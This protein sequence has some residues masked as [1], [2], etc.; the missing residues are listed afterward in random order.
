M[1][2]PGLRRIVCPESQSI[3]SNESDGDYQSAASSL[4]SS[5]LYTSVLDDNDD[6]DDN[7]IFNAITEETWLTP[8]EEIAT[9]ASNQSRRV[10]YGPV[11]I[12]PSPNLDE[13]ADQISD[14]SPI[15]AASTSSRPSDVVTIRKRV[16]APQPKIAA[17]RR[18][19]IRWLKRKKSEKRRGS[20][21]RVRTGIGDRGVPEV[22]RRYSRS[23][24]KDVQVEDVDVET[25]FHQ[26]QQQLAARGFP[27]MSP[28]V[29][30]T[31]DFKLFSEYVKH[32]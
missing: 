19:P 20:S 9:P 23:M 16:A 29:A 7:E 1:A 12:V 32:K 24:S 2:I 31:R 22:D 4:R 15:V 28:L 30:G 13:K 25:Q 11:D 8:T 10:T 27:N 5:L 3:P 21:P 17:W 14:V 6:N 18:G 26:Q